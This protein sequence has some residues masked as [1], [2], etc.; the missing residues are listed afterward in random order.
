MAHW[1][2]LFLTGLKVGLGDAVHTDDIAQ[3]TVD[4][5]SFQP[6]QNYPHMWRAR[7]NGRDY[8]IRLGSQNDI[9]NQHYNA[10]L[11]RAIGLP[12]LPTRVIAITPSSAMLA[13]Y[14][15]LQ[16]FD[17][18]LVMPYIE[19]MDSHVKRKSLPNDA[20]QSFDNRI[21][22]RTLVGECIIGN[23]DPHDGNIR[24]DPDS[25][26]YVIDYEGGLYK[27]Q[28]VND[29]VMM[30]KTFLARDNA[31]SIINHFG[32]GDGFV[33]YQKTTLEREDFLSVL[34]YHK[35]AFAKNKKSLLKDPH[36]GY[37]YTELIEQRIDH[38]AQYLSKPPD[39]PGMI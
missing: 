33:H 30:L 15:T 24:I 31:H 20:R 11:K 1:Q 39:E 23:D 32:L 12:A 3:F 18:A 37:P 26:I 6:V 34:S 25:H 36:I 35:S 27:N 9:E 10:Q 7:K 4:G 38:L 2:Q 17:T 21:A 13:V 8:M 22:A 5:A 29:P 14:P 16:A 19:G 28:H